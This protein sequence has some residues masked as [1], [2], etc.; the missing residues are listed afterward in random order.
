V[1]PDQENGVSFYSPQRCS[2]VRTKHVWMEGVQPKHETMTSLVWFP[3]IIIA[4][5]RISHD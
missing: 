2:G 1:I 4:M 3:I 5:T